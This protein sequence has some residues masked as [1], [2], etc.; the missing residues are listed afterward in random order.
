MPVESLEGLVAVGV[1]PLA[2]SE[3]AG[4]GAAAQR[5]AFGVLANIFCMGMFLAVPDARQRAVVNISLWL[6]GL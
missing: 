3:S 1:G 4:A 6:F 5:I 2:C